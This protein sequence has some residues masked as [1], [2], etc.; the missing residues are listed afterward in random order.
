MWQR[1][2]IARERDWKKSLFIE[3][4]E[5]MV[6]L[7]MWTIDSTPFK[8]ST[9]RKRILPRTVSPTNRHSISIHQVSERQC[10]TMH[11]WLIRVFILHS[12]TNWQWLRSSEKIGD[13]TRLFFFSNTA[14]L[15]CGKQ[16]GKSPSAKI[17]SLP[18]AP[19]KCKQVPTWWGIVEGSGIV[20]RCKN[21]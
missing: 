9:K 20:D 7:K 5:L 14:L 3:S 6:K 17:L 12:N 16:I 1:G 11:T 4:E 19:W 21:L 2:S 10:N 18:E 8:V 13:I 15:H